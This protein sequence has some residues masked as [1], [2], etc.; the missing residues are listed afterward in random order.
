MTNKLSCV[1]IPT[2]NNTKVD[3]QRWVKNSGEEIELVC[4]YKTDER[5]FSNPP[6]FTKKIDEV[7]KILRG[8]GMSKVTITFLDRNLLS[9]KEGNK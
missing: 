1:Y 4:F 5:I 7:I 3:Y 8:S 2:Y 6:D 9:K